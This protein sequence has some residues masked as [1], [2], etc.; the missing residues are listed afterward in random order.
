MNT[1]EKVLHICREQISKNIHYITRHGE[2]FFEVHEE[3]EN[4]KKI[5]YIELFDGYIKSLIGKDFIIIATK[6][7]MELEA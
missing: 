7:K 2:N 3:L 5:Y 1:K 6:I 4:G